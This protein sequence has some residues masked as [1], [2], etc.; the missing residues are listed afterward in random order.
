[1]KNSRNIKT[2]VF[3]KNMLTIKLPCKLQNGI[4]SFFFPISNSRKFSK[5]F[6]LDYT[7]TLLIALKVILLESATC[8]IE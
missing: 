5:I 6:E 2:C 1:M 8:I 3:G 4:M 7:K